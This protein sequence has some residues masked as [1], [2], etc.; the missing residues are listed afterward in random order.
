MPPAP[1][2]EEGGTA[3]L[4]GP[5]RGTAMSRG[6]RGDVR[7]PELLPQVVVGRGAGILEVRGR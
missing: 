7:M 3:L 1:R 5:W 2:G 4:P 6:G